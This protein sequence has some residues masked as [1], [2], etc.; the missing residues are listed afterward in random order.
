MRGDQKWPPAE[1]KKQS[2][3]ENEER[4]RLAQEPAFRPRKVQKFRDAVLGDMAS[5]HRAQGHSIQIIKVESVEA[6]E[7]RRHAVSRLQDYANFFAK[8]ALNQTY[9][10]YRAPP[11]TQHHN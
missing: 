4:R 1:V 6:S 11:G 7:N 9:P 2:E 3:L 8:N 10:G 5:R